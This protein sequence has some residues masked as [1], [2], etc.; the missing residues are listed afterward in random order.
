M[1]WKSLMATEGINQAEIARRIG[2]TRARVTQL[3]RLLYLPENLKLKLLVDEP[4][5]RGWSI[6]R[7]MKATNVSFH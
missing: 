1:E 6:R 4:D 3:M 2:L 5:V 7:A